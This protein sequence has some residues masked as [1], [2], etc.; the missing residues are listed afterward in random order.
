MS[1]ADS[2]GDSENITMVGE[3][4]DSAMIVSDQ[5]MLM[6]TSQSSDS[7]KNDEILTESDVNNPVV[8]VGDIEFESSQNITLPL[9]VSDSTGTPV[10]GEVKVTF[11]GDND[12]LIKQ[13]ALV[14]GVGNLKLNLNEVSGIINLNSDELTDIYTS[15]ASSINTKNIDGWVIAEGIKEI[16]SGFSVDLLTVLKSLDNII[17]NNNINTTKLNNGIKLLNDSFTLNTTQVKQGYEE[18]IDGIYLNISGIRQGYDDIIEEITNISLNVFNMSSSFILS[19]LNISDNNLVNIIFDG[20]YFKSSD[21]KDNLTIILD[22]L[23]ITRDNINSYMTYLNFTSEVQ[24]KIN[25][26]LDANN[27]TITYILDTI[28]DVGEYNLTVGKLMNALLNVSGEFDFNILKMNTTNITNALKNI[29]ESVDLDYN[30]FLYPIIDNIDFDNFTIAKI[31]DDIKNAF[32]INTTMISNVVGELVNITKEITL[33]NTNFKSGSEIILK[34]LN[35]TVPQF[36]ELFKDAFSNT[37]SIFNNMLTSLNITPVKIALALFNTAINLNL[38]LTNNVTNFITATIIGEPFNFTKFVPVLNEFLAHNNK[39]TLNT[40]IS[41]LDDVVGGYLTNIT[42]ISQKLNESNFTNHLNKLLKSITL[43]LNKTFVGLIS[44]VKNINMTKINDGFKMMLDV[45]EFN[46][47]KVESELDSILKDI[48][49]NRT[50]FKDLVEN[51][52]KQINT[53]SSKIKGVIDKINAS[54]AINTTMIKSG[55]DKII[56]SLKINESRLSEANQMISDSFKIDVDAI[57]GN[58]TS[59]IKSFDHN[60]ANALNAFNKILNAL[61]LNT[62]NAV[63][64]LF[65]KMAARGLLSYSI[66]SAKTQTQISAGDVSTIYGN[67][68]AIL[69]TLKDSSNNLLSTK[70]VKV[71]LNGKTYSGVTNANGV[72]SISLP[73]NLAPKTYSASVSFDGDESYVQSAQSVKVVVSKA[74]AKITAK[75]KTFKKS[76]KT[77]KYQITLKAGNKAIKKAKVTLK[78]N[79]K[80]Y[81]VKT[82]NNGKATFKIT[83]L[84]KGKFKAVVKY[85]GNTYYKKTSKSV[86]ITVK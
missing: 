40:L 64:Q 51:I 54:F 7:E 27:L 48:N 82:N 15:I 3:E 33:N 17:S 69:I 16:G 47:T 10:S 45:F 29:F 30:A 44:I 78:V 37:T 86:T 85:A 70:S 56:N 1:A 59:I 46:S 81:S 84:N 18:I 77:K 24:G 13:V 83:K 58:I 34:E 43:D 80:T 49:F 11:I 55:F 66:T 57:M 71:N 20:I 12:T 42:K 38:N 26:I 4:I 68:K 21:F 62:S 41:T 22:E 19:T 28:K 2:Y 75:K 61:G 25:T 53:T 50:A 8:V 73:S 52:L 31:Y 79:G 23:N 32:K 35:L 36:K 63:T 5:D 60:E 76:V 6:A 65:E 74:A 39:L 72:L 9:H 67:S 14:N